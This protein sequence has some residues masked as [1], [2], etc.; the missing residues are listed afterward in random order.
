ML[1][2]DSFYPFCGCWYS[3]DAALTRVVRVTAVHTSPGSDL[4]LQNLVRLQT[5]ELTEHVLLQPDEDT[6]SRTERGYTQVR[7]Q[8]PL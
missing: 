2:D 1:E 4:S 8:C 3:S 5:L 7:I 6:G